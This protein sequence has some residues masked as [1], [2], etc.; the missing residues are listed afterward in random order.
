M[1]LC[2]LGRGVRALM[3]NSNFVKN[4]QKKKLRDRKRELRLEVLP[5]N[6]YEPSSMMMTENAC[7][8]QYVPAVP[9]AN[10][11]L[12]RLELIVLNSGGL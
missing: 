8:S 5:L 1:T 4:R 12:R 6:L 3:M 2:L 7:L 10:F 9:S 11:F